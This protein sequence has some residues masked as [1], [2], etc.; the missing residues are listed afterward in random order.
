MLVFLL[1]LSRGLA[2]GILALVGILV[3]LMRV[4][5]RSRVIVVVAETPFGRMGILECSLEPFFVTLD[6]WFEP[7]LARGVYRD[8]VESCRLGFGLVNQPECDLGYIV[9]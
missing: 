7:L 5:A 9:S 6:T 2:L 8:S 3:R 4:A 1:F